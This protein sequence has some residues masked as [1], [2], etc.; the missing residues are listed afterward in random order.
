MS[1]TSIAKNQQLPT[2][3]IAGA[4]EQ[5][6]MYG[7]LR[8]MKPADRIEYYKN[9]CHSLGLNPL[10]R[11]LEY[12]TLNG[13]LQLYARKD[14]CEQLRKLHGVSIYKIE[15][16]EADGIFEALAY[17]RIAEREDVEMGAASI[18]GLA[19]DNLVNAKLKAITKAKRRLTLSICGLG[20][21]D[22]T[23]I[24]SIPGAAVEI[25][26]SV[27]EAVAEDTGASADD[28]P[29]QGVDVPVLSDED[30]AIEEEHMRLHARLL[31]EIR[32]LRD[33]GIAYSA[34]QGQLKIVTGEEE[35]KNL[36]DEQIEK[37]IAS[38]SEWSKDLAE[39]LKNRQ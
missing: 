5:A 2:V 32:T 7:N 39:K 37:A 21:L 12:V 10:T 15:T 18:K 11:P 20:F 23:E 38:F 6:V 19:G 26:G 4:L 24:E 8:D 22:E 1:S 34:I 3:D 25:Q 30:R 17:G 16:R 13:K 14:C 27:T 9:V 36:S 33:L 28:V 31:E 29:R 35:R